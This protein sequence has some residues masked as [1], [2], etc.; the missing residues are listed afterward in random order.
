MFDI[1]SLLIWQLY[2]MTTQVDEGNVLIRQ[3]F[4]INTGFLINT[5]DPLARKTEDGLADK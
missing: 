1:A 4:F 3:P 5:S 2:K